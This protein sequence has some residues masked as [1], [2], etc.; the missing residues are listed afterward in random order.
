[1]KATRLPRLVAVLG[2][3]ALWTLMSPA[4]APAAPIVCPTNT[5]CLDFTELPNEGGITVTEIGGPRSN[6]SLGPVSGETV[7]ISGSGQGFSGLGTDDSYVFNL[8]EPGGQTISD[9]VIVTGYGECNPD[10]CGGDPVSVEFTSDPDEFYYFGLVNG[11]T[12]ENG[13]RQLVGSYVNDRGNTVNIYVTSDVDAT[14]PAPASLALLAL[15]L[16]GLGFWRRAVKN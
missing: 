10:D 8:L 13:T 11:S 7:T 6:G 9:Q 2:A 3:A 16:A 5:I 4:P 14:V 12:I 15:G 1:M